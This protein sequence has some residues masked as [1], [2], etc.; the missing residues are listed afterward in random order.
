MKE[1]KK[2]NQSHTESLPLGG[3]LEGAQ[4]NFALS[5]NDLEEWSLKFNYLLELGEE[6]PA[7]PEYLKTDHSLIQGCIAKTY[8]V[9]Q[10]ENGRLKIY[11]WSNAGIPSGLI[12]MLRKVFED[13][14]PEDLA[15][16]NINLLEQIKITH[17]LTPTRTAA[18]Q[19]MIKRIKLAVS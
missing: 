15:R 17:H 1:S 6:L 18:L 14:T 13:A 16:A 9:A 11:G 7:M 19:E 10:F 12:E 8:F 5:F 2:D 3:D 4:N